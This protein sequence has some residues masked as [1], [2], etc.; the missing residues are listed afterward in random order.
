MKDADIES[1]T[2]YENE[3][4]QDLEIAI[5]MNMYTHCVSDATVDSLVL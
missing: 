2:F 3:L 1:V 4:E 5:L